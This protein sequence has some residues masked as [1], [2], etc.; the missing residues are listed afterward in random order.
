MQFYLAIDILDHTLSGI[1]AKIDEIPAS[2]LADE[3]AFKAISSQMEHT[4][5]KPLENFVF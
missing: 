5:V 4:L 1:D 3:K 2:Q